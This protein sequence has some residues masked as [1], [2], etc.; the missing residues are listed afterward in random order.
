MVK[1]EKKTKGY[2][3]EIPDDFN[4]KLKIRLLELESIGVKRTKTELIIEYAQLG[5]KYAVK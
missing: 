1:K 5:F 4:T 3:I 2:V